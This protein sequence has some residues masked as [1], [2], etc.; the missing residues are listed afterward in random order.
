MY[1]FIT[2]CVRLKNRL[3]YWQNYEGQSLAQ[4]MVRCSAWQDRSDWESNDQSAVRVP[5][6]SWNRGGPV[7]DTP[8]TS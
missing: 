7:E 4:H 8:E 1:D 2:L 6:T 3:R 5:S